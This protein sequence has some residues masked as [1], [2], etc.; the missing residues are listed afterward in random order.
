MSLEFDAADALSGVAGVQLYYSKDG[1]AFTLYPGGPFTA[2]PI[3]FDASTTGGDGTYGFYTMAADNVANAETAPEAADATTII[4]TQ[5]PAIPVLAALPAF[6]AGTSRAV[7]W[8]DQAASGAMAYRVQASTTPAFDT[9]AAA[10]DWI[11][12]LN[13]TF[14]GLADGA[15]MHYRVQS[16]DAASNE[17]TFGDL[18]ASTQD[19]SAPTTAVEALPAL[20]ST[21]AI[22]IAWAGNDAASGLTGIELYYAKDGGPATML[23]GGPFTTS[24][25]AF[26]AAAL[27][28]GTYAFYTIGTDAVGNVE[29]APASAD[30]QTL[31][32]TTAPGAPVIA[33]LPAFTAGTARTIDWTGDGTAFQVQAATD[34]AFTSVA[35]TSDWITEHT[36]TFSGLADATTY[37]FRLKSRDAAANE[38]PYA[39]ALSSTQ[40]ATAP[41]TAAAA[42]PATSSS[43]AF[44]I[45]WTGTDATSGLAGVELYYSKDGGP[46]LPYAGGPYTASPIAF[47]AATAGGDGNYAFH[48][49][50]ADQVGNI[51]EA[52][53]APDAGIVV[54]TAAPGS[55]AIASLTTFTAGAALNLQWSDESTSGAAEYRAEM[56]AD[57][58]FTTVLAAADWS[59]SLAHDF[60][61]LTD[62]Q[63]YFFRVRARDAA[64]NETGWSGI[65]STTMDA[66][67]PVSQL[68]A[69]TA[70]GNDPH[71]SL[72]WTGS[73]ATSGVA[74]VDLYWSKDGAPF[75]LA[76]NG[77]FDA[78][79]IAFD[80]TAH[81]DGAYAFYTIARD[82][83]GNAEAAPAGGD[84]QKTLD[85]TPSAAPAIAALPAFTAGSERAITWADAAASGAVA[86]RAQAA[87]D[88]AFSTIVAEMDWSAAT[89]HT[90]SSLADGQ[91]HWFRAQSRDAAGNASAFGDFATSTQDASAPAT[92]VTALPA[93]SPS[94][95][96][97]IAWTGSD[98]ASGIAS[99]DLYFSKDGAPFQLADGSPFTASPIAFDASA[100]GDGNYAFYS[101]ATDAV[102]NLELAPAGADAQTSI[103]T[104]APEAPVLAALAGFT[105]GSS[106]LASWSPAADAAAYRAQISSS[107]AFSP[108]TQDTGWM[109]ATSFN[110]NSLADATPYFVRVQSRDAALNASA[111][112]NLA[113]TVMD[114]SAPAS[115]IAALPALLNT[116]ALQLDWSATDMTSGVAGVDLYYSRNGGAF[117]LYTGSPF[118]SNPIAFE[119]A[120][121]GG[122]G[123]YAFYTRAHDSV[124]NL[125]AAPGA[126]DAS[127]KIDA[128][129]PNTPTITALPQF[130]AGSSVL[131]SWNSQAASGAIEYI[132]EMSTAADFASIAAQSPWL[133]STSFNFPSLDDG[134]TYF[135]RVKCRD[136]AQNE[137]A[138]AGFQ[139]TTL[140]D[141]APASAAAPLQPVTTT[142][143]FPIAWT[144][145]DATS[146]V[147]SVDLYYAKDGGAY[148]VYPGGPWAASPIA[149]DAGTTGGQ[150][151]Y[152][153]YTRARDRVANRE[154]APGNPDAQ[155]IVNTSA[156]ASPVL[157]ALPSFTAGLS[158]QMAWTPGAN[159]T[160][161]WVQ[162][163][164][165]AAFSSILAES[166]W[167]AATSY[168]FSGLSDGATYWYRVKAKNFLNVESAFSTMLSST[169]DATAPASQVDALAPLYTT[170]TFG[171]TFQ[172]ADA[173]SGVSGVE[174]YYSRNGSAYTAYPGGPFAASPLAFDAGL[175]GGDGHYAFYTRAIDNVSNFEL[176]PGAADAQAIVSTAGVVPP[177]LAALPGFNAGASC[178]VSWTPG[179]NNAEYFAQASTSAT[180]ASI[181]AESGW[182]AGTAYLFDGL[183][184]GTRYYYRVKARNAFD[185]ESPFSLAGSSTQDAT[186]P[187]SQLAALPALQATATFDLAWSGSDATSGLAAV[188]LYV[189]RNGGAYNE[190]GSG[191]F[192]ASPIAIDLN[193]IGGDGQYA[194][195][196]RALD[197][198]GNLELAPAT[199]DAQTLIDTSAPA[200]PTLTAEP[201][202]TQGAVNTVDWSPVAGAAE[203]E[204]Q[205]AT[206][207][208]FTA[209]FGSSN[210]IAGTTYTF[211]GLTEGTTYWY[212]VRARDLAQNTSGWSASVSSTQASGYVLPAGWN[213]ISFNMDPANPRI[214]RTL[215]SIQ[216]S[217]SLVRAYDHGTFASYLPALP[218][219]FNDLQI[220]SAKQ[221][222]WIYMTKPDTLVVAGTLTNPGAAIDLTTGWN[223]VGYLP[224]TPMAPAT[225]LAT[226][227]GSYSLARGYEPGAGYRTYYPALP[228][229]SDLREMHAGQGYWL[230]MTAADQLIY[231]GLPKP[232][233]EA[234]AKM[235]LIAKADAMS[236]PTVMDVWSTDFTIDGQPAPAGTVLEAYN[237]AD[238][239]CG[240]ATVRRDGTIGLVHI[241][242]DVSMTEAI[243]GAQP[244]E[245]LTLKVRGQ[246]LTLVSNAGLNWQANDARAL[247]LE[248]ASTES[249]LP[250]AFALAQNTPNPFNPTTVISYAIPSRVDGG[251]IATA[252]V[253][254]R[255]YDIRGREVRQL[256]SAAQAPGRY[257][258]MWD[259]RDARGQSVGN[260]IYFYRLQ[261]PSFAQARKMMLVK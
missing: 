16:R 218:V 69:L 47:D 29:A 64:H 170:N 79:P 116:A 216:G 61:T 131:V 52:P 56:A 43:L 42:L 68:E 190:Y 219:E 73:D 100:M 55:P 187:A 217:Y 121:V 189:S 71:F 63:A 109:A 35:A 169:Q 175:T 85:T 45:S 124:G 245:T 141:T 196:T 22:S 49:R 238:V 132:A 99:V 96:L 195:Y 76:D 82:H 6:T 259:G 101:R 50:G 142:L 88:A 108:M 53:A 10:S 130:I 247:K 172:A 21:N 164:T 209:L 177:M 201:T 25:I 249:L 205:C 48:V 200:L 126:P 18:V 160:A 3:A 253:D 180:F 2:S 173:G 103:D 242:G 115:Q 176:A 174:L 41:V 120:A 156:V 246:D 9:I 184:D 192:A 152:A 193:T 70:L 162:A 38:S 28:D 27:G 107:P 37:Y 223:L 117:T 229:L 105:P 36:Y 13:F 97:S 226:I 32:D 181:F 212:R 171:I 122:D 239:L 202:V 5:A 51:E 251:R 241:L 161:Y 128:T 65:K 183:A 165:N 19:A 86:Y 163:S 154:T 113:G 148:G 140:D 30:A 211:T 39:D 145:N 134:T 34:A 106:L 118:T 83:V 40:D 256:V 102:G 81:G 138:Q 26:D 4:D 1:G 236:V 153:F 91:A 194:F 112:S 93:T 129:A 221:G 147:A 137:S 244:G 67:A 127:T 215:S 198:A 11:T 230:Y 206:D 179:A 166:G 178:T 222:Y 143:T 213:L 203:Y 199:A 250:K 77:P 8:D 20:S 258:V 231:G 151:N 89:A 186:A 44:D 15:M 257:S 225:A 188:R 60:T 87:T 149:F 232:S 220:M 111:F 80:A 7:N 24:P 233:V 144:G 75:Q 146:G 237:A 182:I 110:F 133:G 98:A 136:A 62:G 54:D 92:Q 17:S 224:S 185:I 94:P 207:A 125:E 260:G 248:F 31:I 208:G 23:P 167:I 12:D 240:T 197:A 72:A 158:R 255:I 252:H 59:A 135:F 261:T 123:N 46:Y 168:S 119:S 228:V 14:N 150:G 90:F 84:A 66:T 114:A 159:N 74:S 210:W 243:E 78:S 139:S 254:L 57:A 191:P 204:V 157:A 33:A 95:A 235:P 104:A 214:D 227:S 58:D 155:T 234:A